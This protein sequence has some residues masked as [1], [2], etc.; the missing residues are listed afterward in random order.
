MLSDVAQ[1]EYLFGLIIVCSYLPTQT[2]HDM[3]FSGKCPL[4]TTKPLQPATTKTVNYHQDDYYKD[5]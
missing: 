4:Q 2:S 3:F 5:S 1:T